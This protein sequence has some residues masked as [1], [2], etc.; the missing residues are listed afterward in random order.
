[1]KLSCFLPRKK[2][3]LSRLKDTTDM[4][5]IAKRL[6]RQ[7]AVPKAG[8]APVCT[9]KYA[10]ADG[11]GI[12]IAELPYRVIDKGI[13]GPGLLSQYSSINLLITFP[14]TVKIDR[15][16]REGMKLPSSTL[17]DWIA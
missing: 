7:N 12:V 16:E 17:T 15:F 8:R 3:I 6:R 11:Q 9:P 2:L 4:K 5:K 10:K 14:S 13:P 1:M